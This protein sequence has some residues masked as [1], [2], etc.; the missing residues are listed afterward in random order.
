MQYQSVMA[1]D[2]PSF[3]AAFSL[4]RTRVYQEIKD[5]RL[6]IM[7]VGRRTLISVQAADEWC[8]RAEGRKEGISEVVSD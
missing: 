3:C 6:R 2:I 4:G 7:K 5:G 1:Y 8:R